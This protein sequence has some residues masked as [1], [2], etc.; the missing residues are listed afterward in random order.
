MLNTNEP[1]VA[2]LE[3]VASMLPLTACTLGRARWLTWGSGSAQ[4]GSPGGEGGRGSTRHP[5]GQPEPSRPSGGCAGHRSYLPCVHRG[6]SAL[7]PPLGPLPP[8]QVP[9]FT[10][11]LTKRARLSVF[12]SSGAR[13]S[14]GQLGEMGGSRA[15]L[16]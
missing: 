9:V 6:N 7:Q 10:E 8:A 4:A 12:A 14:T 11:A 2:E 16:A 3:L 13:R 1:A 5:R 15:G